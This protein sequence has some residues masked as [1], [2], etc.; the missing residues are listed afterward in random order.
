[1][2]PTA[3]TAPLSDR[4]NNTIMKGKA[5]AIRKHAWERC[6]SMLNLRMGSQHFL[7]MTRISTCLS[8]AQKIQQFIWKSLV[9]FLFS[10]TL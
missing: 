8:S 4:K 2:P 5:N 3:E 10:L 7:A 6:M 1:M 9:L